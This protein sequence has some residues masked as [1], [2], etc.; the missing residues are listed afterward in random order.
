MVAKR[1]LAVWAHPDD[2]AFGPVGSMR[3]AHDQGW[4]TAILTATRGEAGQGH[5]VHLKAGQTLGD[6]REAEVRAAG[7]VLG[8]KQVYVWR[9]SDGGL[10]K[11]PPEELAERVLD[12]LRQWQPAVV[13]T[14]GP[15]GITAHP[16]H[17]AV[18]VATQRAFMKLRDEPGADRPER[19]YYA[20]VRPGRQIE[21]PMGE[22]PPPLPPTTVVDVQQYETVKRQALACHASQQAEW[23]PLLADTDWL[24]T[25]RF[26]RAFPPFG[27][28]E[29]LETTIL[30][31]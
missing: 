17:V 10:Q 12:V 21:H 25:D 13:L 22:A 26:F 14:F 4:E 1:L 2:E 19:L 15:D 31:E 20:T 3:L 27:P 6:V 24:T 30:H 23:E 9:Y 28:D 11:V 16:D 8:V 18:H 29:P 5:L 7:Q